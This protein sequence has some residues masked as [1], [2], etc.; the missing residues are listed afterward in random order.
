M[1][2]TR[3]KTPRVVMAPITPAC[4]RANFDLLQSVVG[5]VAE[6]VDEVLDSGAIPFCQH[7]P[8]VDLHR[9]HQPAA[10]LMARA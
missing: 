2:P 7:H 1:A 5:V 6:E 8:T 3:A 4:A 9:A 10:V